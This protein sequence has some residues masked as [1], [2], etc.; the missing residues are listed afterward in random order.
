MV[1]LAGDLRACPAS[2]C[3]S[4]LGNVKLRGV[5][6]RVNWLKPDLKQKLQSCKEKPPSSLVPGGKCPEVPKPVPLSPVLCNAVERL[7][8]VCRRQHLGTPLFLTK[9]IQANPK[10]WQRFW[11]Q[12]VIPGFPVPF[13]GFTW[14]RQDRPG[15]SGHEEAK[16][17][18][19]L[20]VLR[21][22]GQS[23][24]SIGSEPLPFPSPGAPG[25]TEL[26]CFQCVGGPCLVTPSMVTPEAQSSGRDS[27]L[28]AEEHREGFWGAAPR[29]TTQRVAFPPQQ[30][31]S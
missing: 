31:A 1:I 5:Q 14:V 19:A 8:A 15:R 23:S 13:S 6:M 16:V 27:W 25:S 3:W 10:G 28:E 30:P 7:H 21:A 17:A 4:L 9:F 11:C 20:H 12:V 2:C 24:H 22:L 18:V 29:S 26:R